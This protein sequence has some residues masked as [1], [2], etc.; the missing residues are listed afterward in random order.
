VNGTGVSGGTPRAHHAV[1]SPLLVPLA[2]MRPGPGRVHG[3]IVT[4]AREPTHL[5]PGLAVALAL[6]CPLVAICGGRRTDPV[7]AV[8]V[9]ESTAPGVQFFALDGDAWSGDDLPGS[10]S[11]VHVP[12]AKQRNVA[13]GRNLG[14][15][16]A[17]LAGWR[18][19]LLLDDDIYSHPDGRDPLRPAVFA[20]AARRLQRQGA[21]SIGWIARSFP[22][23]SVVCHANRFAENAQGCFVGAGALLT[24]VSEGTAMFPAVYND[25]WLFLFDQVLARRVCAA[26]FVRQLPFDPYLDP[27]RVIREEFGDLV[28]EALFHLLHE[29]RSG[30]S[31][32]DGARNRIRA[33]DFWESELSTRRGFVDG[34]GRQLAEIEKRDPGAAAPDLPRARAAMDAAARTL[35]QITVE[36]VVGFVD[37]WRDDL[38]QWHDR[39]CRLRPLGSM[40]AALD[41]LHVGYETTVDQRSA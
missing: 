37:A 31:T 17:R 21:D 11:T 34:I 35:R 27:Q 23:N 18:R 5:G 40:E 33:R 16:V 1:H 36:E 8:G 26:G 19:V 38:A 14:L 6:G 32:P 15:L 24:T 29:V 10:A 30:R 2:A 4:T 28:A 20:Q 25:D 9:A 3:V 12:S 22:D 7:R 39:L 13:I 41:A